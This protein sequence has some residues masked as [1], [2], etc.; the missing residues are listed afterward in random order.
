MEKEVNT[1]SLTHMKS[2][3]FSGFVVVHAHGNNGSN[4]GEISNNSHFL[5]SFIQIF[6]HLCKGHVVVVN[7]TKSLSLQAG[8]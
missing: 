5:A 2:R 1:K 4:Y 7:T 3:K 8:A 6:T